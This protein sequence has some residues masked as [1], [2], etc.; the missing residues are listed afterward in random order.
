M[1]PPP[2]DQTSTAANCA[3]EQVALDPALDPT[4]AWMCRESPFTRWLERW[5]FWFFAG[6]TILILAGFNG[7]WRIGLDSSV[8]R[9][10]AE[11]LAT[12]HGYTFA[13]RSHT[14]VYP[15]LPFLMAAIQRMTGS[16]SVVPILVIMNLLTIATLAVVYQLVKLRYPIWIAVIVTCG[17]AMNTRF[18]QQAQEVMTDTPFLFGCVTAMLGWELLTRLK[19]WK[20]AG[21]AT[22]LLAVGLFIAATM[23]PTFWVLAGAWGL[24]S[25]WSAI[26]YRDRK[27][28]IALCVLGVVLLAFTALDPRVRGLNILQGEYERQLIA[29][30]P[31]LPHRIID[32]IPGLFVRELPEAFFGDTLSW[33]QGAFSILLLAGAALVVRRQPLWGLQVFLLTL[34][35]LML[36]DVPRYYLMVLPELWLG[37]VLVFLNLTRRFTSNVPRDWTLF[38]LVSFANFMNFGVT[39]GLLHEQHAPNFLKAYRH[40]DYLPLIDLAKV[41]HDKVP[42]GENVIGP[43]SQLLTYLS[44]RNV[45]GAFAL[46]FN[47]RS[48]VK[49]AAI[50]AAA[51]PKWLIGP[52]SLYEAK[53]RPLMRVIEHGV[54]VPGKLAF[55]NKNFWLSH[56]SVVLPA[57]DWRSLPTT[58]PHPIA[59]RPP[60]RV[61]TPEEIAA[62]KARAERTE[63]RR[64]MEQRARHARR[65]R[66]QAKQAVT[67]QAATQPTTKPQ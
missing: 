30:I 18:T 42:Q 58:R 35:M 27:A 47:A 48:P 54:I 23:R 9:G 2:S 41:V 67:T 46:G 45:L 64:V 65:L 8:Y 5:R 37:Y 14:Q 51:D 60:R 1:T 53:D 33:A 26:R 22:L 50:V 49:H 57:G 28:M 29:L 40:G 38:I 31:E 4:L 11:N 16:N 43:Y 17:V 61:I 63:H 25:V 59:D 24:T 21:W 7:Q 32:N 13:G 3:M 66:R 6:L 34:A 20:R 36:S 44:G 15:G 10:I 12:G 52:M 39:L 55:V 19:C 56:A 62:R